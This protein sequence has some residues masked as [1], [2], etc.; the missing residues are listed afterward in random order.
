MGGGAGSVLTPT[1]TLT[2]TLPLRV[3]SAYRATLNEPRVGC[4]LG[5]FLQLQ[6][7]LVH[8]GMGGLQGSLPA[9]GLGLGLELGL[10]LGLGLEEVQGQA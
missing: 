5:P 6:G 3:G 9:P 1:L 10:R 2:L 4:L 7:G 8:I